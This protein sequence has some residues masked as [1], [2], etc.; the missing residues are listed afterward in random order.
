[1]KEYMLIFRHPDG[2]QVATPE[3]MK[4]WMQQT[5]DWLQTLASGGHFDGKSH[6]FSF[7][8]SCVLGYNNQVSPGPFGGYQETVGGYVI[9]RAASLEEAIQCAQGS[10]VLQGAGNTVEIRP[11]LTGVGKG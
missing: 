7:D 3:Q 10:P 9:I 11:I 2:S 4:I 8:E 6:G 1:M 5:A